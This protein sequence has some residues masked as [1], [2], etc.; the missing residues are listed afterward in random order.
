MGSS[1]MTTNQTPLPTR[2]AVST[3]TEKPDLSELPPVERSIER[4]RRNYEPLVEVTNK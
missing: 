2:E 3:Q 4:A 1:R